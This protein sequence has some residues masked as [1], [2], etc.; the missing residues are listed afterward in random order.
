LEQLQQ[1]QRRFQTASVYP[2]TAADDAVGVIIHANDKITGR[3]LFIG[4]GVSNKILKVYP[5]SGGT[6]KQ[7]NETVRANTRTGSQEFKFMPANSAAS[8]A[9]TAKCKMT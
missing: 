5:P 4:N 6:S 2:T 9:K 8:K 3:T 7:R 1:T